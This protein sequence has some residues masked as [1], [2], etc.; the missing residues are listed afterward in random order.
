VL[1]LEAQ[2]ADRNV[3]IELSEAA[4][5]WLAKKGYSPDYGARPLAR[6]IQEHVKKPLA[7]ELLF[8]KLSKGGV[9]R[10]D[11]SDENT[12]IFTYPEDDASGAASGGKSAEE[13]PA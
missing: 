9:V 12:L 5:T 11:V 13:S 6:I 7:E 4:R 3:T 2:L 8:G 1:E 10:V